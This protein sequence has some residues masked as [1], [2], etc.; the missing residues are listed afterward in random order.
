MEHKAHMYI[1]FP[2][3]EHAVTFHEKDNPGCANKAN[4]ES[5]TPFSEDRTIRKVPTAESPVVSA[6]NT[7]AELRFTVVHDPE[8]LRKDNPVENKYLKLM[9]YNRGLLDKDLKPDQKERNQLKVLSSFIISLQPSSITD[10]WIYAEN[11]QLSY[12][13]TAICRREGVP[14]EVPILP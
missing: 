2:A 14:V 4:I 6:A 3:F 11:S 12:D 1:E 13:K 5:D 9:R 10:S 8:A 7:G